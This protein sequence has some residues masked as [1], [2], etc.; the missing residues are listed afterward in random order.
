MTSK[1][2]EIGLDDRL[3]VAQVANALEVSRA[4]VYLKIKEGAIKSRV[5][6]SNN[7]IFIKGSE[8]IKAWESN[9]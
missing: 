7:K 9:F 5:R 1:K 2:P 8:V 4:W 6:R 3:S